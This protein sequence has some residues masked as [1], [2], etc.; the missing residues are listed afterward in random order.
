[1]VVK[2][3]LAETANL[4]Q[5]SQN[6]KDA[7]PSTPIAT[8]PASPQPFRSDRGKPIVEAQGWRR[9]RNGDIVLVAGSSI[10]TLPRPAQP[11]S[12]CVDR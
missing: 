7:V 5:K 3:K 6:P 2:H 12:G 1:V 9:E 4:C 11:Q 8:T 10:G